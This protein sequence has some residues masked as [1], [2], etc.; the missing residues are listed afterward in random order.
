MKQWNGDVRSLDFKRELRR[1]DM[2]SLPK[3]ARLQKA[4]RQAIER[5][6]WKP[7]S[8]LPTEIE[9]AAVTPFSL[10]TVQ[11]AIR[12]LV[13]EGVVVR[14]R[15]YGTFVAEQPKPMETPLHCRFLNDDET[16]YLPVFP[17]V[18]SRRRIAK[19]GPWSQ[20]LG[21][22]GNNIIQID[23]KI[24]INN[25]F[26]VYSKFFVNADRLGSLMDVPIDKLDGA[27]FKAIL[28][29][30][31]NLSIARVSQNMTVAQFP[32]EVCRAI[33]VRI[34]TVGTIIE[35]V[36]SGGTG[37]AIYYQQLYVPPSARKLHLSD[38]QYPSLR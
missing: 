38:T 11:R 31:F 19:K 27:N 29:R 22:R 12:A 26:L 16:G 35:I 3:Y 34:G 9:L 6:L 10:G 33:A 13:D 24:N 32:P 20:H 14:R 37:E 23:R 28:L 30:D 2:V 15:G 18:V 36:A 4:L 17:K 8:K 25:E 5:G 21:Q 1:P 7:G